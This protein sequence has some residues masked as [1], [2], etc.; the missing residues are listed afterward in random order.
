M[1]TVW[2]NDLSVLS[3]IS[4]TRVLTSA[5]ILGSTLWIGAIGRIGFN[6]KGTTLHLKGIPTATSLY[7]FCYSAH[8]VFPT[9]Y[10]SM[11][12]K[13]QFTKVMML[14]FLFC[15]LANMSMAVTG[16]L[17]FGSKV[18][19]QHDCCGYDSSLFGSLMSLVGAFLGFTTSV[20][21]PCICY[22]KITGSS[23]KRVGLELVVVGVV[24]LMGIFT[25]IVGTWTSLKEIIGIF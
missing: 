10:T 2:F 3:C 22:L 25:A 6:E 1:P 16:Y 15:T 4:A 18:E 20:L 11:A 7:A 5:I 23:C 19:S 8:P 17:M 14:C 24:I 9:L 12:N 13:L 21:L